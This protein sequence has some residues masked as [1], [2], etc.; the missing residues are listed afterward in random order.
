LQIQVVLL[1]QR[2]TKSIDNTEDVLARLFYQ[3]CLTRQSTK[4]KRKIFSNIRKN[5]KFDTK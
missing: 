5:V 4:T 3:P 1:N 2:L